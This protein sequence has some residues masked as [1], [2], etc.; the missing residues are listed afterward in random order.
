MSKC[1]SASASPPLPNM[2]TKEPSLL[3]R[4][5]YCLMIGGDRELMVSAFTVSSQDGG[6][7]V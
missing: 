5:F 7:A 4:V 3:T 6:D 2:D 1:R